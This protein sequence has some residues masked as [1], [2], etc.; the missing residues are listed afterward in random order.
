V[1]SRNEE[2][3]LVRLEASLRKPV[4]RR[5]VHAVEAPVWR[6]RRQV[7]ALFAFAV[8][9]WVCGA[10]TASDGL[11]SLGCLLTALVAVY[12]FV[13]FVRDGPGPAPWSSRPPRRP[14][15]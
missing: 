11:T 9:V 1:L 14:G 7:R 13:M 15:G 8:L 5:L 12:W 2:L 4:W 6:Y 10:I 3:E